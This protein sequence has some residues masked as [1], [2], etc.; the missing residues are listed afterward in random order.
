MTIIHNLIAPIDDHLGADLDCPNVVIDIDPLIVSSVLSEVP[1]KRPQA[2]GRNAAKKL[3]VANV[4]RGMKWVDFG[5]LAG[6]QPNRLANQPIQF[7]LLGNFDPLSTK[8]PF[9]CGAMLPEPGVGVGR[10]RQSF[11]NLTP[12]ACHLFIRGKGK[13]NAEDTFRGDP[14]HATPFA[15]MQLADE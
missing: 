11:F 3:W 15:A 14:G 4:A 8:E 9:D 7:V 13:R 10:P 6:Y 1:G 5:L 12:N 2:H